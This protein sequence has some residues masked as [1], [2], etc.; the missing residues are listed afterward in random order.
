MTTL[1]VIL[2]VM[3]EKSHIAI[4]IK[5]SPKAPTVGVLSE[6]DHLQDLGIRLIRQLFII[7]ALR[8]ADL[9]T[10]APNRE[11]PNCTG[12]PQ[13]TQQGRGNRE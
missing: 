9:I 10:V 1:S 3:A 5:S 4:R 2:I 8:D 11:K 6:C 7:S 12:Y 13:A